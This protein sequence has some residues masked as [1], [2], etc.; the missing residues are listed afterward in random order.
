MSKPSIELFIDAVAFAATKHRMQRRKDVEASPYINHPIALA[1]VLAL[2]V[3]VGDENVL[4]S[5]ILHDTIEDTKTT[6]EE[7]RERFG[8]SIAQTVAEVT[9]DKA[10]SPSRRKELQVEH[11]PHLSECAKLIKLA[12]KICNL[13]DLANAPPKDWDIRRRREYF[14]WAK[15]VIDGLRGVHPRLEALFD[16]AYVARP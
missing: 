7:L 11:S 2:E 6:F 8:L 10:L 12:D 13:R 3:D 14:D 1:H 9:D 15:R 4:I 16:A 5:A